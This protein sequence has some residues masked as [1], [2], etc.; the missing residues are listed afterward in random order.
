MALP[1]TRMEYRIALSHVDR[2]AEVSETVIVGRHPSET[3]EHLTL[4]VLAWCL[5]YEP[6]IA[7]GPGLS[8]PDAADLWTH[9][10]TGRLTTWIEC[11]AAQADKLRKVVQHHPGAQ[12]H[13]VFDN[14]RRR[15]ELVGECAGWKRAGEVSLWTID[16]A[17]VASLAKRDERRHRWTVTVVGDHFYIDADDRPLDGAV[18]RTRAID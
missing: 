2:A 10:L 3:A 7:F 11:G 18:T 6:R 9:D 14:E 8:T 17:L 5:L 1:T 13:V 16:P 15:L 4:R 12:V